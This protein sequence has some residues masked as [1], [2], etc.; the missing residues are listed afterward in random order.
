MNKLR[1]AKMQSVTGFTLQL[2]A[3]CIIL[4]VPQEIV[5]CDVNVWEVGF[6]KKAVFF[7]SQKI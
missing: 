4:W 2:A 7:F 3:L 5:Q 6:V 1:G